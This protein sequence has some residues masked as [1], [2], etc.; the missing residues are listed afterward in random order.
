MQDY[1]EKS[2]GQV[3]VRLRIDQASFASTTYSYH[4]YVVFFQTFQVGAQWDRTRCPS[5]SL[6]IV[7]HGVF[8]KSDPIFSVGGCPIFGVF[9][10][11]IF[12]T[13]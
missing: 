5:G 11:K 9:I 10:S 4:F 6:T 8:R 1:G 3:E 7:Q 2:K 12:Q 13:C